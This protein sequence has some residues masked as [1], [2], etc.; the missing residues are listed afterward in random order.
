M[1]LAYQAVHWIAETGWATALRESEIVFPVV[2]TFHILGLGLLAGTVAIV[3]LRLLGAV[4]ARQPAALVARQF[5]P[6]TW[7]GF[8][9]M[10]ISGGLL[11]AAQAEHI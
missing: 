6:L 11:F 7:I 9:V 4:L 8:A 5:L 2:Q 10:A 3:D 1:S